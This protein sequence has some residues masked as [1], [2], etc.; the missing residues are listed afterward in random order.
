MT[1]GPV[2]PFLFL[3]L[4]CLLVPNTYSSIVDA[5]DGLFSQVE[6]YSFGSEGVVAKFSV[7]VIKESLAK[8]LNAGMSSNPIAKTRNAVVGA[9]RAVI[10]SYDG[11]KEKLTVADLIALELGKALGGVNVLADGKK[12]TTTY[13][14]VD[15]CGSLI[16][17]TEEYDKDKNV[18]SLMWTIPLGTVS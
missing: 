12:V 1:I 3:I 18:T 8:G 9:M 11:D 14:E 6:K 17:T 2:T 10:S 5:V 7:P 15:G 4:I 13:Y 16:N